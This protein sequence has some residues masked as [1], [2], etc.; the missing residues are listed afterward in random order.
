MYYSMINKGDTANGPGVR[1]SLFVS[2]C[3]LCCKGC[4][5]PEAWNPFYGKEFTDKDL[6]E[7]IERCKSPVIKGLSILGGDPLESYN[8]ETINKIIDR[9]R[10]EF[11]FN[12]TIW[13]WTGRDFEDIINE[14]NRWPIVSKLDV[15]VDGLFKEKE[16][17][18][19]LLFRGSKNQ[20]IIDIQKSQTFNTLIEIYKTV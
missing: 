13:L 8:L 16:K 20:R 9:F 3:S 4:F 15:L 1:V 19:T 7:I 12:K 6:E 10:K 5:N 11:G 17:D 2:G 18:L 14:H